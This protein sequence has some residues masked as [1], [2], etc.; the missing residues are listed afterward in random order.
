MGSGCGTKR[1]RLWGQEEKLANQG[2]GTN[3]ESNQ[4][5]V[6][7]CGTR[8]KSNQSNVTCSGGGGGCNIII[9]ATRTGDATGIPLLINFSM[10]HFVSWRF[11]GATFS[12]ASACLSREKFTNRRTALVHVV[13]YAI[14]YG[15]SKCNITRVPIVSIDGATGI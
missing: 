15:M 14:T 12:G 11:F 4:S 8:R 2:V 1:G 9:V 3:R 5:R 7:G 13:P 10:L 6:A